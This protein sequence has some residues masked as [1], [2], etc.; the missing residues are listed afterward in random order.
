MRHDQ[1]NELWNWHNV[2][3][4]HPRPKTRLGNALDTE[5][6]LLADAEDEHQG[7]SRTESR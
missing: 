4:P 3:P 2:G 7:F 1:L 5:V 6:T